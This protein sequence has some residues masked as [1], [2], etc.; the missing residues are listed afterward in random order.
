MR[1][2][3]NIGRSFFKNITEWVKPSRS[4]PSQKEDMTNTKG[5]EKLGTVGKNP[6]GATQNPVNIKR[7]KIAP[8]SSFA[9]KSLPDGKTV[10]KFLGFFNVSKEPKAQKKTDFHT[11]LRNKIKAKRIGSNK[12]QSFKRPSNP[13]ETKTDQVANRTIQKYK[14]IARGAEKVVYVPKNPLNREGVKEQ[15]KVYYAPVK[16]MLGSREKAL[17]KEKA[18]MDKILENL[19]GSSQNLALVATEVEKE[20]RV[21]GRYTLE[22]EKATNDFEKELRKDISLDQRVKYAEGYLKGMDELHKAHYAYGDAKPENCLVY[23]ED[24]LKVS[25][26]GKATEVGDG[27]ANYMGN[28]RFAPPEGKLSQKGDVYGAALILIRNFEEPF[29]SENTTSLLQPE[30]SDQDVPPSNDVRGVER[31]VVAHKAFPGSESKGFKGKVRSIHRR[32]KMMGRLSSQQKIAHEK[33]IHN[34]IDK[35]QENMQG[36][37]AK[38]LGDLLRNMTRS[39]PAQRPSISEALARYQE[40]FLF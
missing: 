3:E 20:Q 16:T 34:Y 13:I 37:Q 27:E 4:K 2:N 26:F 6:S 30:S 23:G 31:Y 24:K 9:K 40:I 25:D 33:A 39:D 29:L 32:V 1:S 19:G 8:A 7:S 36:D 18:K 22:V 10:Q 35:L 28:T 17:R 15:A 5:I 21:E 11:E 12:T 14:E 38:P